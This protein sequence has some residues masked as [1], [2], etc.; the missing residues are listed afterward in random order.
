MAATLEVKFE[1]YVDERDMSAGSHTST[2]SYQLDDRF[3]LR[4]L[5]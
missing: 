2:R 4:K 3:S 1:A 5:A